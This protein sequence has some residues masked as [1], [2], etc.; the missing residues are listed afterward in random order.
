MCDVMAACVF[1]HDIIVQDENDG[2]INKRSWT[3]MG[4]L[5]C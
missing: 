4:L 2:A 5:F 3:F 1:M